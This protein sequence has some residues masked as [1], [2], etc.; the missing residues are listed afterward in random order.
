MKYVLS[1]LTILGTLAASTAAI[2]AADVTRTYTSG[3][4][5]FTCIATGSSRNLRQLEHL[6]RQL[7]TS[8]RKPRCAGVSIYHQVG[9]T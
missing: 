5:T 7:T 4:Y 9:A 6:F 2:N 3:T 1:L 8:L